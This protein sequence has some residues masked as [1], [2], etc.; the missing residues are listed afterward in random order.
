[1]QHWM[2]QSEIGYLLHPRI[3]VDPTS[4]DL[5]IA[6]VGCGSGTSWLS[7]ENGVHLISCYLGVWLVQLAKELPD[8][9][10]EG[11]DVSKTQFPHPNWLPRN[12]RLSERDAFAEIPDELVGKFDIVHAGIV[13]LLVKDGNPDFLLNQ[14]LRMLS[15]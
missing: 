5:R 2:W 1:M 10:L 3:P 8:A 12:V 6:D 7:R 14:L 4:K 15:E 9:T 11:F 13:V